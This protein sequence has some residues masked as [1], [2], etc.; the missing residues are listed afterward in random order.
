[1]LNL[2][3]PEITPL[4]SGATGRLGAS[5]A[6]TR[7]FFALTVLDM[8]VGEGKL[9]SRSFEVRETGLRRLAA[10]AGCDRRRRP[11]ADRAGLGRVRC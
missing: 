3:D 11:D 9:V 4:P 10:P 1:M 6:Q 2:N 8:T 7:N 5:R